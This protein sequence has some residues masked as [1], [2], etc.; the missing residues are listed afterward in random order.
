MLAGVSYSVNFSHTVV[1]VIPKNHCLCSFLHICKA[2]LFWSDDKDISIF[3]K[4]NFTS[5]NA[6][7]CTCFLNNTM[8]N[9][10]DIVS[11]ATG[12]ITWSHLWFYSHQEFHNSLL[13]NGNSWQLKSNMQNKLK[14]LFLLKLFT[15]VL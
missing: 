13:T 9:K 2:W 10:Y 8:N 15:I 3:V 14:N 6:G 11:I 12:W 5:K 1:N 4:Q 7:K